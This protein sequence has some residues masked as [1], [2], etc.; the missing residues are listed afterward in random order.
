MWW[1]VIGEYTWRTFGSLLMCPENSPTS[2][3]QCCCKSESP[4]L[5]RPA[6]RWLPLEAASKWIT[7]APR[8][9]GYPLPV[10]RTSN[11]ASYWQCHHVVQIKGCHVQGT[12]TC[13]IWCGCH[14][15][16]F[17]QHRRGK[18]SNSDSQSPP[19]P[20]LK[21]EPGRF[22]S[23]TAWKCLPRRLALRGQASCLAHLCI[24]RA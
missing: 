2:Y 9:A 18:L 17:A 6:R 14:S 5:R 16:G 4:G 24:S 8:E 15:S 10:V 7:A 12:S 3:K 13:F 23:P 1:H 20:S 22:C 11:P 21:S 19:N